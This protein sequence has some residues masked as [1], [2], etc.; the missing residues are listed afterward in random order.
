MKR[1]L[2]F[3]VAVLAVAVVAS[4]ADHGVF[5]PGD[6]KWMDAPNALPPGAKL[7]VLEGNPFEP[8]LYTMRLQMPAG[9]RIPPHWH[10]KDEHVTVVSGTFNLGMGQKFDAKAATAMPAGTFGFLGP[11]M[12]HFAFASEPTVIQLHGEGPWGIY[13]VNDADD[14]RNAK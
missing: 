12:K 4:A 1:S 2:I 9:Y 7:A 14:P 3:L 5:T 8:G 11:N 6:I 13:Y 10:S